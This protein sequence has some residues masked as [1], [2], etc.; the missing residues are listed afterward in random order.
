MSI[1]NLF[2]NS[3]PDLQFIDMSGRNGGADSIYPH[4]PPVLAKDLKPLKEYQEKKYEGEWKFPK[5]P[6]MFDYARMGYIIPA[7]TNF[8]IKA[9][10][11]GSV[12]VAGSI[13]E[14]AKTRT[15]NI[16]QPKPMDTFIADGC[17]ELQDGINPFVWN[18]PGAWKIMGRGN[19]SALLLPP[20]YH[21][22]SFLEDLYM[23]AGVV[24]YNGFSTVNFICSPKRECEVEIKAGDPLIHVIPFI[25]DKTITASYGP[26]S[27]EQA[28]YN[29]TLKWFHEFNFY[30]RFYMIRKKY[31]IFKK[32]D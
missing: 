7:W 30:R 10:K 28:D 32:V 23:Y 14:A 29:G 26:A 22:S 4:Y 15:S 6:G 20:I 19:V 2:K 21:N 27:R 12:A 1:F 11:A 8:H 31:K 13:G 25:T 16:P 17:F 18:F 5:C 24:D 9:N 3:A